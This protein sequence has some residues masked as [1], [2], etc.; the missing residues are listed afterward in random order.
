MSV[1]TPFSTRSNTYRELI[2]LRLVKLL[3]L[4]A[5]Q[6]PKS[7]IERLRELAHST[8]NIIEHTAALDHVGHC[9]REKLSGKAHGVISLA[10]RTGVVHA[11][12]DVGSVN[13]G[14]GVDFT[15]VS[16]DVQEFGVFLCR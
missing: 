7:A 9:L 5:I 11:A 8:E 1:Y 6:R 14:E 3:N 10:K 15:G 2:K 16:A 13:A 4:R 12:G